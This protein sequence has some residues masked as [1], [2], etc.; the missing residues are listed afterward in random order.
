MITLTVKLGLKGD[1][2]DF[3]IHPQVLEDNISAIRLY[4]KAGFKKEGLLIDEMFIKGKYKDV[5]IMGL[6]NE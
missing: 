3:Y 6:I 2:F 4:E 1:L 5:V